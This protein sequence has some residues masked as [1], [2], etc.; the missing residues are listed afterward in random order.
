MFLRT[1]YY[2]LRQT[3]LSLVLAWLVTTIYCVSNVGPVF[4]Y[5]V[6]PT[7][8]AFPEQHNSFLHYHKTTHH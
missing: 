8:D 2:D 7:R 1:G 4:L 3:F 6:I 5:V